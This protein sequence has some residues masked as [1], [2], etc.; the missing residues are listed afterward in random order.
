MNEKKKKVVDTN[1]GILLICLF[2]SIFTLVDFF[3]IDRVLNKYFD[4]SKCECEK[5]NSGNLKL[6]GVVDNKKDDMTHYVI[7]DDF[8]YEDRNKDNNVL[9][10]DMN[11]RTVKNQIVL[12]G[13]YYGSLSVDNGKLNMYIN[14]Y[15]F[16]SEN[17]ITYID[18]S[19][20]TI[21]LSHSFEGENVKYIY[22]DYFM[23]SGDHVIWVLTDAGN[24]YLNNFNFHHNDFN[25]DF[26]DKFEKKYSNVTD[27]K[28]V[29]N[30]HINESGSESIIKDIAA[31][32]N[33]ETIVLNKWGN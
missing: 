7:S 3:V 4:Y 28:L 29:D 1:L 11:I 10:S 21:Y 24:V 2:S 16:D 17:R 13:E 31:V 6:D 30:V 12:T 9:D 25:T 33:G 15:F 8:S 27:L 5:C 19:F 20:E 26:F 18:T 23:P 14:R 22:H 32:I